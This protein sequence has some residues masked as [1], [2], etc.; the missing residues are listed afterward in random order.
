MDIITVNVGQGSLAI[1][2][3]G[4]EAIIADSRI[5]PSGDS[6]VAYA[7]GMLATYLKGHYVRGLILTGFDRDHADATGVGLILTKY[8]PDWIM[9]PKC[10]KDTEEA[11]D[12]F[13][14]VRQQKQR[15]AGTAHPLQNISVCLDNLQSRLLSVLA[16]TFEFELFSPHTED[17]DNSNNSGIV[18][19]MQGKGPGG[20]SYLIT[21]D[22]ENERWETINRFF[23]KALRSDVMAGPHHGSRG[24]V[25]AETL[26]LV[27][28]NTVLI[29]AGVDNPY[30]H[31][32]SQAI[33]A[34]S[35]VAKHVYSTNVNGG[36]SLHT[37]IGTG[38]FETALIQ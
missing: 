18:V 24:A 4:G 2:R 36:V 34:F 10:Y 22:T 25:N 3:H 15:R 8:L 7:K 29:S 38:D 14:I 27:E 28:P 1:V 35:K 31:P 32:D 12:V 20:F 21:G 13:Q 19:R 9:Y 6:R 5:P 26:L 11:G 17:M 23:G 16:P 30:G 37:T 33:A